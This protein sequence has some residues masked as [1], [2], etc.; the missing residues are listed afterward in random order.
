MQMTEAE[1]VKSYQRA[2]KKR[3]QIKILAE[4]NACQKQTIR[5]ILEKHG[6]EVPKTGNRYTAKKPEVTEAKG[7]KRKQKTTDC[8]EYVT[9]DCKDCAMEKCCEYGKEDGVQCDSFTPK[10]SEG[11]KVSTREN[12]GTKSEK[13][14]DAVKT[15][16]AVIELAGRRAQELKDLIDGIQESIRDLREEQELRRKELA[17]LETWIKE[18]EGA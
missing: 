15:P 16:K 13:Q 7:S 4:L 2:D 11:S 1:I 17:E 9:T 18:Q 6:E 14:K 8:K 5:D 12:V 3:E 10:G